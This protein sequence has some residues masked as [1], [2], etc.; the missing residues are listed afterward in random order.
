MCK[1][2]FDIAQH[3]SSGKSVIALFKSNLH[4]MRQAKEDN[5]L[6]YFGKQIAKVSFQ[7]NKKGIICLFNIHSQTSNFYKARVS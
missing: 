4:I 7:M 5:V 2:Q 1:V 3:S 6:P